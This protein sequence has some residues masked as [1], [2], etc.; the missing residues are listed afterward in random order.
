MAVEAEA[1]GRAHKCFSTAE[2]QGHAVYGFNRVTRLRAVENRR[3]VVDHVVT[4]VIYQ[5]RQ[6]APPSKPRC[7]PPPSKNT[8]VHGRL[9]GPPTLRTPIL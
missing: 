7:A 2:H 6:I 4:N 9:P 3:H 5:I 8:Y 1:S